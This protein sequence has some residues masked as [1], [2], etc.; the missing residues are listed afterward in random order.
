MPDYNKARKGIS[1]A[2]EMFRVLGHVSD[3]GIKI[4]DESRRLVERLDNGYD[5]SHYHD[6][7][8][9][10]RQTY[11]ERSLDNAIDAEFRVLEN[12]RRKNGTAS[13]ASKKKAK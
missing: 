10:R 8:F 11:R 9:R 6:E 4:S 2:R 13:K 5:P 1:I 3:S 7:N 12:S